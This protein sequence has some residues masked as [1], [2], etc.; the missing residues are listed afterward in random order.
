MRLCPATASL[1]AL[2]L[3]ASHSHSQQ[4]PVWHDNSGRFYINGPVSNK[5]RPPRLAHYR[6]YTDNVSESP[7][8]RQLNE[9]HDA[10]RKALQQRRRSG[11]L[12]DM[13]DYRHQR[14]IRRLDSRIQQNCQ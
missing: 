12:S 5:Q 1:L 7:Y 10:Y 13:D 11:E 14:Q 9:Q 4:A 2:L 6:D 8:C 3:L